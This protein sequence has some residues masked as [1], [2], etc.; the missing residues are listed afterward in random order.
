MLYQPEFLCDGFIFPE[1]PRWHRGKFY[2]C[3]IDEGSIFRIHADGSKECVIKIDD[4][5]SGWVFTDPD[6]DNII[7]TSGREKKLL[8]WDGKQLTEIADFSNIV[9]FAL[10]DMIRTK[11]GVSFVAS[12]D[13]KFG[14][15]DPSDAPNSPL[16]RADSEG[17]VSIASAETVFAN[18]MAIPPDG[19]RLIVAD[20]MTSQLRQWDLDEDGTLSNHRIFA[21]IPGSVPDGISL[22]AEGGVWVASDRTHRV[23]RVLE[24]GE[25]TDEIDMGT[26]QATAC[27]LGGTD[28]RTLLITASDSHDRRVIYDNPTGRLFTVRV[29]VPGAGL[30]SWY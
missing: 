29:A 23:Y 24:G 25:I 7:L 16:L 3:S 28:G 14:E 10:N 6:A 9:S 15:I 1:T 5:V 26:T 2:C 20:S 12:V 30:P 18:G 4:W 8:H 22:D 13:F 11:S 27:M 19:R 21:T 17:N